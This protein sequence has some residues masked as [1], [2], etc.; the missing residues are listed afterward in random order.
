MDSWQGLKIEI[1]GTGI[2]MP[3]SEQVHLLG[4][5]LGHAIRQQAGDEILELTERL[6]I[7]CKDAAIAS[8]EELRDR[9]AE[10]I[11]SLSTEQI[12]WLLRGYTSFFH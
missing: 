11:Q 1:E 8:K 10:I 12:V 4:T 2:T 5:L 9:A 7:L 6:R 3:L